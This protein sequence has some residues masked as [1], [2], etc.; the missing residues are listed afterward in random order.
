MYVVESSSRFAFEQRRAKK[1]ELYYY[2]Y[3]SMSI[4]VDCMCRTFY[5]KY[6]RPMYA[7]IAI[8]CV[9]MC[10]FFSKKEELSVFSPRKY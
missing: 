9:R 4:Y 7:F 3:M 5:Q 6:I 1:A 10:I 2:V 8:Q